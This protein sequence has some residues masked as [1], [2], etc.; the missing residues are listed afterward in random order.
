MTGLYR[1]FI[2]SYAEVSAPLS[3]YLKGD[4]NES[5]D[6]DP[7]AMKANENL[8]LAITRAPVLAFPNQ[9]G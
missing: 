6:L 3:K 9:D 5:F 8:K 4:R 7:D 1:K 2:P